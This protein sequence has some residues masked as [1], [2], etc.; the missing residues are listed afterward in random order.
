M[1]TV[2]AFDVYGTLIDTHGL[3]AELTDMMGD[4]AELFSHTWRNKQLE[5]SFRRGLMRQYQ[6]FSV[7]TEQALRFTCRQLQVTLSEDQQQW[8]LEKYLRLP[9]FNDVQSALPELAEKYILVAFSNGEQRAVNSLLSHAGINQHFH[10]VITADAVETFKPDPVIYQHLLNSVRCAANQT[11]LI[12]SNPFDVIGASECGW[13]TAW[14]KR[15]QQAVFDPW[16]ITPSVE[17]SDSGQLSLMLK[18]TV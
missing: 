4:K 3:L 11:W 7:C 5:Y 10:H 1:K 17:I 8:L 14:V 9:A 12:S 6:H 16:G 13:N 2:L 15:S 18:D